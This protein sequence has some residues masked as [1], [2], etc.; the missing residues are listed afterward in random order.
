MPCPHPT[1]P[2]RRY[3]SLLPLYYSNAHVICIFFDV[4]SPHSLLVCEQWGTQG[5]V[6]FLFVS[7]KKGFSAFH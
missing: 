7:A 2:C 1:H 3:H 5:P 4:T 6:Y